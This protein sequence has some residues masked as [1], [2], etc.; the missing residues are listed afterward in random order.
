[1][2]IRQQA[3][4]QNM[5]TKLEATFSFNLSLPVAAELSFAA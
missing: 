1:M 4:S 2:I 5:H 3:V